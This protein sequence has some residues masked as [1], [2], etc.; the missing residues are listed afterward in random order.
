MDTFLSQPTAHSHALNPKRIPLIEF[1]NQIKARAINS[2]EPTST[3]LHSALR[4]FSLGATSELSRTEVIIQ[5]IHRQRTT[6]STESDESL[7]K[8]LQKTDRS[9]SFLLYED[10]EMIIFTT[11]SNLSALKQSKHRFANGTFKVCY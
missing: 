10:A 3:I 5:T 2:D 7:P 6:P 1:V 11:T 9:E 8:E 4:T